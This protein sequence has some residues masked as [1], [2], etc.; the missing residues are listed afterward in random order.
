MT[1]DDLLDAY[2]EAVIATLER[3][4]AGVV[5]LQVRPTDDRGRAGAGSGFLVTPDGY[6]LTN[7]HVAGAGGRIAATL[8]DG[9]EYAAE[10]VG[11]DA[12]TDLA[13]LRIGSP[14]PL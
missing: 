10:L 12:D 14:A 1:D 11:G 3:S 5:A 9:S 2:S 8:D 13:L 7:H 4:R 6:L